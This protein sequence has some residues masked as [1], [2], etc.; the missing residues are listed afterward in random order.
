MGLQAT[1]GYT[2]ACVPVGLDT[3]DEIGNGCQ[4]GILPP[5]GHNAPAADD[6]AIV[7]QS[8]G[9]QKAVKG[10]VDQLFT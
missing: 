1:I 8:E 5:V 4:P 2:M 3:A 9:T 10:C 7:L 6:T